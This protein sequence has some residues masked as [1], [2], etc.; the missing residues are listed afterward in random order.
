MFDSQP[1]AFDLNFRLFGTN[2]R[3]HPSFWIVTLILGWNF[4]RQGPAILLMWVGCVFFSVLLH[5]FGHVGMGRL[6]GSQGQILLH[7][8]GGLAMGIHL[9]S[10]WQ[11][12]LMILGGPGIQLVLY[13][14]LRTFRHQLLALAPPQ[15]MEIV[16]TLL[17][18]LLA[19]N[20][21]WPILNLLP[22]WPLDGGQFTR[23]VMQGLMG[24]SGTATSLLIST[25]F[26]ATM[27]AHCLMVENGRPLINLPYVRDLGGLYTGIFFAM[28]AV[29]S[30]QSYQM[31]TQS[32]GHYRDDRLPWE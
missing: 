31:E 18:M 20:L 7:S 22:V 1:T 17:F 14:L 23:E 11:R 4:S 12:I 8:M 19:I 27:A 21:Y 30:F 3:V 25:I 32:R 15:S 29:S 9:R 6:F 26:A 28:F 5:E 16:A 13:F 2:V 24:R 10:R